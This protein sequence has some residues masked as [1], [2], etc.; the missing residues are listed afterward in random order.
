MSA[1][2][3]ALPCNDTAVEAGQDGQFGRDNQSQQ[4]L[5]K[6]GNGIAGFDFTKLNAFGQPL[7]DQSQAWQPGSAGDNSA[8]MT[9]DCVLDHVTNL[10]WEVKSDVASTMRFSGHTYSWYEPSALGNG[11]V[12]GTANGGNCT[13]TNCDTSSYTETLNAAALC[14]RSNWRLPEIAELLSIADQSTANP[15]LDLNYFPNSSFNAYWSAQ[16]VAFNP[17]LAWYVYFTSAGNS[18]ITKSSLAH[19]RLVSGGANR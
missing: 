13:A 18:I 1:E 10:V 12:A 11:G 14:G 2:W 16:T 3:Q 7:V 19:I 5:T 6:L 9:W 4:Q 15:P 17:E 8:T